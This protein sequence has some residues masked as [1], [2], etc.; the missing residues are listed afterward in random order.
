MGCPPVTLLFLGL[1]GTILAYQL[2][3]Q[4]V[5]PFLSPLEPRD[6]RSEHLIAKYGP[7][8]SRFEVFHRFLPHGRSHRLRLIGGNDMLFAQSWQKLW[9]ET[10]GG[11]R[12]N[13]DGGDGSL[14]GSVM[15]CFMGRYV[16]YGAWKR[17]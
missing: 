14:R 3:S 13:Y 16:G 10:L 1:T 6:R 5:W 15:T 2:S 12:S 11:G 4:W 17:I 8:K 9:V 7:S